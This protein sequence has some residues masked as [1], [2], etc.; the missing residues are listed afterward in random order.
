MKVA[1]AGLGFV[2]SANAALL[3]THNDVIAVDINK[4]RVE[5][6]NNLRV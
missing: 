5:A 2:G 6:I 4:E 3:S 1:V